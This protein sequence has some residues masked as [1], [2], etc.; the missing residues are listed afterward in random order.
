MT[1]DIADKNCQDAKKRTAS[2]RPPT[3]TSVSTRPFFASALR[4][5]AKELAASLAWSP[6]KT[7]EW[8]F[9]NFRE[10]VETLYEDAPEVSE[11]QVRTLVSASSFKDAAAEVVIANGRV[12]TPL[13]RFS[14]EGPLIVLPLSEAAAGEYAHLVEKHLGRVTRDKNNPFLARQTAT[15]DEGVFILIKKS[16]AVEMPIHLIFA[17]IAL[18]GAISN[19][20]RVLIVAQDNASASIV[21]THIGEGSYLTNVVTELIAGQ[22]ASITHYR[23]QQ[24]DAAASHIATLDATIGRAS[25]LVTYACCIGGKLIRND[26][27][28]RLDGQHSTA[29][30]NGLVMVGQSQHVDN[31]TLLLH[32]HPDCPSYELYK[33]VL[34]GSAS[35]VFKGKIFVDQI[36]QKTDAKQQSKALLLTN[37]AKINSMPALEIYADDV[38]CTHG[39]TTGPLDEG[40]IFYLQSRGISEDQSK[41]LLTYAFLA[42]VTRRIAVAPVREKLEALM[43]AQHN[44][45]SDF[46]IQELTGHDEAAVY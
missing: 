15:F 34:D 45:P 21:E 6:L 19:Y 43:A 11:E 44:L 30:L 40:M 16:A 33:H 41:R 22:D 24:D 35:A 4:D 27:N 1:A 28:V 3:M 2:P 7:E 36:A 29:T 39:S 13:C 10:I 38:K 14:A 25:K 17:S 18:D 26:L 37:T 20:P 32:L 5:S 12:V 31:H 42:D 9:T 23:M 8:K 46:R